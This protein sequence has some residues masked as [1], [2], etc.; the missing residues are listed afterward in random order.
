MTNITKEMRDQWLIE[1]QQK[2]AAEKLIV[3]TLLAEKEMLDEDGYPSEAAHIIVE[4][5]SWEDKKGWFAFIESI[6]H[7]RSWGWH[8]SIEPHTYHKDTTVQRFD[9]STAGWSGNESLIRAMEK[10]SFMWATTWVQSR[11]GGH[12]IFEID[13]DE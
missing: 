9:I 5:W 11:R 6:W 7:L 8:E 10:N 1:H 2:M 3:D 12:Y 13:N 4:L